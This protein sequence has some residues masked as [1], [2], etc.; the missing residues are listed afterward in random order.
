MIKGSIHDEDT[1]V[2]VYSPNIRTPKHIKQIL[3]DLRKLSAKELMLLNC[4]VGEDS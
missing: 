3:I 4:G 1:I 2:N